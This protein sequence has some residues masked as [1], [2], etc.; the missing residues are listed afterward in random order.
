[1]LS[2]NFHQG[3]TEGGQSRWSAP[4]DGV[5]ITATPRRIVHDPAP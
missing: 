1:M 5:T 2:I 4:T 3:Y